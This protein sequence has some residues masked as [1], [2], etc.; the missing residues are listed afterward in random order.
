[1]N[2]AVAPIL[3]LALGLLSGGCAV[4]PF[5]PLVVSIEP[6]SDAFVRV[7]TALRALY[8]RLVVYDVEGQKLQSTWTDVQIGRNTA[9]RRASVYWLDATRVALVVEVVWLHTGLDGMPY[10]TRP[11]ADPDGEREL[12]AALGA[13]FAAADAGV[14]F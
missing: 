14:R 8:P 2:R 10:W 1:M 9:R 6:A 7:A 3:G 4:P 13:A 5:E 11:A 12:A